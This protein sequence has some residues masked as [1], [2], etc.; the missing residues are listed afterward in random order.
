MYHCKYVSFIIFVPKF[1]LALYTAQVSVQ[2]IGD[3]KETNT[4]TIFFDSL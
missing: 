3:Y 2:S 1:D 4:Y